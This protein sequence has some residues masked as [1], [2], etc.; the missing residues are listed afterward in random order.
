MVIGI[1]LAVAAA[2]A[3]GGGDFSGGVAARR[4]PALAVAGTAQ[5]VGLG[6]LLVPLLILRPALPSAGSLGAAALAG[7]FGGVGLLGLYRGMARGGMGLVAAISG[8]GSVLIPLAVSGVLRHAAISP[9]QWLGVALA[10]FAAAAASGASLG[11][12]QRQALLMAGVAA[13]GFGLWFTLL[14][15]AA[16]EG[17]LWTIVVSRASA[18]VLIGIPALVASRGVGLRAGRWPALAAGALDVT[19]NAAFVLARAT[20]TVGLA[21]A[22]AG[23]Y[24]IVTMSLAR[25]LTGERLPRLGLV[26]VVLAV[27]AIVLISGG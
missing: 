4:A 19:G 2:L 6:L 18:T 14:D 22:V 27:A 17:E 23:V 10:L 11:G 12:A 26:A 15:V 8:V 13:I 9:S 1:P 24:P 16:P 25:G 3:F 5:A 21:A 20:L 7:A